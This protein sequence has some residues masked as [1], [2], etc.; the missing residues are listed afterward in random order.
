MLTLNVVSEFDVDASAAI[1]DGDE[2]VFGAQTLTSAGIY[3]ETFQS[4]SGCDSVVHLDLSII[5]VY[6]ES[7]AESICPGDNYQFGTQTLA[8]AGMYSETFSSS[9]GCDSTVTLTL[10]IKQV[11]S[12]LTL[13]GITLTADEGAAT[14]QWLNCESGNEEILGETNRSF[15]PAGNGE[16]AV[17]IMKDECTVV[18]SCVEVLVVSV[19]GMNVSDIRL[20]PNP[21]SDVLIISGEKLSADFEIQV[22]DVVGRTVPVKSTQFSDHIEVRVDQ[23]TSGL[24]IIAFQ[25]SSHQFRLRFNKK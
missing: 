18:S 25:S 2:Y 23:L 14:Y 1:C 12:T 7:A 24:Y 21:V 20:Y 8:T 5:T 19:E 22:V 9:L 3:T 16:Y 17:E 4:I 10:S 6:N 13:N 11:A 15:T